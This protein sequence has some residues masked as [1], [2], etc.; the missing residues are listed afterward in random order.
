M[1]LFSVLPVLFGFLGS[2]GSAVKA[3]GADELPHRG[4]YSRLVLT[5]AC[6][7]SARVNRGSASGWR[8]HDCCS[9][10]SFAT[11]LRSR[12]SGQAS[13]P[14]AITSET[15]TMGVGWTS[16]KIWKTT[17]AAAKPSR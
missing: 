8:A 3:E 17:P 1:N 7:A 11:A 12:G 6:V 2:S 10:R 13:K 16:V 9:S 15:L 5:A 14:R 4:R